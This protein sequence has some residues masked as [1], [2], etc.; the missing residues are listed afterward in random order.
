M[1]FSPFF[2][3][4][5]RAGTE[6]WPLEK[7]DRLLFK[8]RLLFFFLSFFFL[9][10]LGLLVFHEIQY[11][12]NDFTVF[13]FKL[14]SSFTDFG[15]VFSGKIRSPTPCGCVCVCVLRVGEC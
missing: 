12:S 10:C 5:L 1:D 2:W 6:H 7:I 9:F 13:V 8:R 11:H 4:F 3:W 14:S 15:W